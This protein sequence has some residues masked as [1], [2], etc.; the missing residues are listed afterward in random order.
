MGGGP[1]NIEVFI[2]SCPAFGRKHP[3]AVNLFEIA[4]G[5]LIMLLGLRI[6]LIVDTQ[7]PFAVFTKTMRADEFIFFLCRRLMLAPCIPVVRYER[8]PAHEG[9]SMPCTPL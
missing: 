2:L 6:L 7:M 4:I 9:L 8:S 1:L 3:A 5:E